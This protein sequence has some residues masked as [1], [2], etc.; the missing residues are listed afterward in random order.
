[1]WERCVFEDFP[2][3]TT[4]APYRRRAEMFQGLFRSYLFGGGTPETPPG[5]HSKE[6]ADPNIPAAVLRSCTLLAALTE[7]EDLPVDPDYKIR[8][9]TAYWCLLPKLTH[10]SSTGTVSLS[11]QYQPWGSIRVLGWLKPS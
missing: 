11:F 10:P 1:M 8:V 2:D 3:Q 4:A 6:L 9:R 5:Q 7:S